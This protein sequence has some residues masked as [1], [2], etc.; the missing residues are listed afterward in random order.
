[1]ITETSRTTCSDLKLNFG[2][3]LTNGL[4]S[5]YDVLVNERCDLQSKAVYGQCRSVSCSNT[6]DVGR[7]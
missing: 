4:R 3:I 2:G 7:A 1:M 6:M 5:A